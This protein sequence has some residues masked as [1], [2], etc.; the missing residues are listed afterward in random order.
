MGN[1]ETRKKFMG[2]LEKLR[3]DELWLDLGPRERTALMKIATRLFM[4]QKAYGELT[5][6]KKNWARE[7]MEEAMDGCVYLAAAL[8]DLSDEYK[9]ETSTQVEASPS[10]GR[11]TV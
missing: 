9:H 4:G 3:L 2:D 7:A 8:L 10:S 11:P 6:R 5:Y 1:F